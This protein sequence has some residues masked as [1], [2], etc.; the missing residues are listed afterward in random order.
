MV[1]SNRPSER[2][3]QEVAIIPEHLSAGILYVSLKYEIAVHLC[4]CGC[5]NKVVTPLTRAYWTLSRSKKGVTLRPSIGNWDFSC[6]S[7]YFIREG[8]VVWAKS[9]SDNQMNSV[10]KKDR[11]DREIFAKE[12]GENR[13]VFS[14]LLN[15]L[16][17]SWKRK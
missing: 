13:N 10:R 8:V 7:H 14:G 2:A 1:K 4:A 3:Y 17:K 5:M 6:R 9:Y 16:V 11:L 15:K 12:L